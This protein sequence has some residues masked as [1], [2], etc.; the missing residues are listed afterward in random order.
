MKKLFLAVILAFTAVSV[1]AQHMN[2]HWQ[3]NHNPE[4]ILVPML[5]GVLIGIAVAKSQQQEAPPPVP[6]YVPPPITQ[7]PVRE[8]YPC[9]I[10]VQDP[11]TGYPRQEFATCI[12]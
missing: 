11:R 2:R 12:R 3:H 4:R 5:G 9:I 1:S 8:F 10:W 7:S 6:V